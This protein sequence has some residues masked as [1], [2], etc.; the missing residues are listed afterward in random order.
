[1][2]TCVQVH[3]QTTVHFR[4]LLDPRSTNHYNLTNEIE[5]FNKMLQNNS[6]VY[7]KLTISCKCRK[8]RRVRCNHNY[9]RD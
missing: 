7:F 3:E 2:F 1:M 5:S 9:V 8:C 4:M 6:C